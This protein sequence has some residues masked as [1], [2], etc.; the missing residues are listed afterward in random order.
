MQNLHNFTRGAA[1]NES[2][3]RRLLNPLS[4]EQIRAAA[5][6]VFA[7]RPHDSRSTRYAYI[8]T[9]RVL[10]ALRREGFLPVEV[11]QSITRIPG[12]SDFTKHMLTFR[13]GTAAAARV[14]DSIPQLSLVNSHDGSSSY[15]LYAGLHRFICSNGLLVCDGEFD[16]ISVQHSGNIRDRVIEGSFEVIEEAVKAGERVAEW[17]ALQLAAPEQEAFARAALAL[18]FEGRDTPPITEAQALAARR[19]EDDGA[20][21]W[22]VFNRVQENVIKGG[23]RYRQNGRRASVRAVQG[24]DQR[25]GLNR[26][27][28]RLAEEMRA[29]KN[30]N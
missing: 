24:I 14:G 21:L 20:D 16:S 22:T 6:S 12:R 29:I 28:W 18:R 26:A 15:R 7:D 4:D 5:P 9:Y 1:L 23:Q 13:H 3:A 11:R 17:Q 30:A 2:V 8:P 25:T 19:P 27:L 10:E